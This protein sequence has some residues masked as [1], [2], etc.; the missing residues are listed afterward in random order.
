[1]LKG[2]EL[3]PVVYGVNI[4]KRGVN[5]MRSYIRWIAAIAVLMCAATSPAAWGESVMEPKQYLANSTI[6]T[7]EE[8]R[9]WVV[10]GK[11]RTVTV[12][13][14]D[15][16]ISIKAGDTQ[17]T[18]QGVGPDDLVI[19]SGGERFGASI[20]DAANI[21]IE[22]Y[23]TGTKSGIK[24]DIGDIKHQDTTLDA[25]LQ[26]FVC[27][28]GETEELLC[29]VVPTEGE[30]VFKEI[31]W[32]KAFTPDSIE[33]TAVPAM[34]GMLVPKNWPKKVYLYDVVTHGRVYMPWW[35]CQKGKSVAITI[36]ETPDDAAF[37]F[38]HPEG[39]PTKIGVRWLHSLGKMTYPR[40]MRLAFCEEGNYVTAAK[41]YRQYVIENGQF[42][43]LK[44]KIARSPL[45]GK[46]VGSPVIHTSILYHTQPESVY[47]NKE[48]PA[49]NHELTSFDTRAEQ[50]R[51]F[52]AKGFGR[53]Y[54]HLDGWGFRGYDNMH[55]DILPPCPEAGGWDG[56]RKLADTCDELG[57]VFALHDQY[58]DYYVDAASY[59]D[60]HTMLDENG[61]RP[62]HTIWAGG[63][64]SILCSSLA[65]DYV[66]RN[67]KKLHE[68]GVKVRGSYLDVFAVV[69]PDECYNPEHPVTRTQCLKF[70]GD[71]LDIVRA[72]DGVVSSEE[73]ADWAIPHIDLVHHAPHALDPNPTGGPA[74]GIPVP[75]FNLVYHDALIV[76]Y[77]A[78]VTKG[79]W[80]IPSDD[81]GYL[82][83][84]ANAG[85]PYASFA[86]GA[87]EMERLRTLCALHRRV[88]LL[89]MT[90]HEF[91]DDTHRKWRTTYADGTTVAVDFDSGGFEIKPELSE[92]E[93]EKALS[94]EL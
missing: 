29:E 67:H 65:P 1:M 27:L 47:Y 12:D 85:V 13:S 31:R 81:A 64:Q 72:V 87:D 63:K 32:P 42:V 20:I 84:L 52:A 78:N 89:E 90:N 7:V 33:M 26:L 21:R 88:G 38:D 55:P 6:S 86:P 46:L 48:N 77:F 45:V 30:A 36:L 49:A 41:R 17:W 61:N 79:G 25:R 70:R 16:S 75:L 5:R 92:E 37:D 28:E 80:G 54:I 93:M 66:S 39:G 22:P 35:S 4:M 62:F 56:M 11:T 51:N 24:I 83:A 59:D 82:H 68:Q 8:N 50:L 71:C 18:T 44:E 34:Q 53:A 40:R 19:Q 74:M 94:A 10:R 58:R 69:P 60:R 91:T 23:Q 73:P 76:P 2:N 9:A 57:F 3:A 15:L 14:A 43:S